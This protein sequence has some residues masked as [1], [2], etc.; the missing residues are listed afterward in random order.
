MLP[1]SF[2]TN[3]ELFK[4]FLETDA[5]EKSRT[6]QKANI[7][8]EKI[9]N[10][11]KTLKEK[12]SAA[13]EN[14]LTPEEKQLT[15]AVILIK[16]RPALLIENNKF[17]R[18]KTEYWKS[19]LEPYRTTIE[20][21]IVSV[22]RIELINDPSYDYVG[23]GWL[24]AENIVITNRHVANIFAYQERAKFVFAKNPF[25]RKTIRSEIDFREEYRVD[26]EELFKLDEVLYIE[27]LQNLDIAFLK[28]QFDD[29]RARPI[30][31][32]ADE[33]PEN[34]SEVV[35]IGYP[36]QD[37]QRNPLEP[38]KLKEIFSDIY[39]VK[40]LQPGQIISADPGNPILTHDCSTL[41]GNSGSVV[42]DYKRGKAVGLHFGGS[43]QR[44]NYAVSATILKQRLD[45]WKNGTLAIPIILESPDSDD[46]SMSEDDLV[47][48]DPL[49]AEDFNSEEEDI[50]EAVSDIDR[51]N[52]E[53]DVARKA[54]ELRRRAPG[55]I[56]T[57]GRRDIARQAR[58]MAGNVVLNRRW[59]EQTYRSSPAI[60]SLQ[61]WVNSHPSADTVD[62][63][64]NGLTALMRAMPQAQL[65]T[66]SKHLSG[67]AFD[68]KPNSCPVSAIEAL[69]P[70]QFLQ[71]EGGLVIWHVSF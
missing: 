71:R 10:Y 39:D 12:G 42:L 31:P 47:D 67:R 45:A 61:Q 43:F 20:Q 13:A 5:L 55:V 8:A 57:S 68:V 52:L 59:I 17:E 3:D 27:S 23:T 34:N 15:E 48:V 9:K 16:N 38:A 70:R 35:V 30:I 63:I 14:V 26:A 40:R 4:E 69:S 50:L 62:E 28:V 66:I 7:N 64:A 60:R 18:P 46:S 51:L 56:F 53:A 37:S 32:L 11:L 58:A 29:G 44:A 22:G 25:T 19:R 1:E 2:L 21:A 24:I 65:M 36:A 6:R 49:H 54:K 41:G 33:L